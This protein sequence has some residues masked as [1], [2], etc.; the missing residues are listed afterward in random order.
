M[1]KNA[2]VARALAERS[3]LAETAPVPKQSK[4]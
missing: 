2:L 4:P 3:K 1:I